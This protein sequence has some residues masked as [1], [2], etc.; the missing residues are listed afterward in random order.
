MLSFISFVIASKAKQS[1]NHHLPPLVIARSRA[2]K[3]SITT[4]LLFI[5]RKAKKFTTIHHLRHCEEQGDEAI[6]KPQKVNAKTKK[7]KNSLLFIKLKNNFKLNINFQF[8]ISYASFV[9]H[10]MGQQAKMI[11]QDYHFPTLCFNF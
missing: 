2:T 10:F 11:K 9:S 3:Q 7:K 5:H 8:S 6:H 4:N 1:I